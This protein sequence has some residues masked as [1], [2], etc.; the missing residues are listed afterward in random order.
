MIKAFLLDANE[1]DMH[2]L[3][4]I[5]GQL[6]GISVIGKTVS[7]YE[8]IDSIGLL[9]PDALFLDVQLPDMH[10]IIVAEQ[11]KDQY[12]DVQIVVVTENKNYALWAFDQQIVDYV[13]K[14]CDKTRLKQALKRLTVRT[15]ANGA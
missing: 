11:I 15:Q 6:E 3:A 14:P 7:P 4:T 12:P 2:Q 10:G 8:A 9:Q 5:L 13:L 1:R